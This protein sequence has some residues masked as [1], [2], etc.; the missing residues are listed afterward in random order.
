MAA[1]LGPARGGRVVLSSLFQTKGRLCLPFHKLSY[2]C[3][4]QRKRLC[5]KCLYGWVQIELFFF[6]CFLFFLNDYISAESLK[7]SSTFR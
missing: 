7:S 2:P 3:S 4:F 6:F 5:V 1:D